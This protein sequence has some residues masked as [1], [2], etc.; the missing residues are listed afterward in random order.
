VARLIGMT[1]RKGGKPT[2]PD[3]VKGI[4]NNMTVV[5]PRIVTPAGKA[6]IAARLAEEKAFLDALRA[7]TKDLGTL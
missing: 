3:M 7:E 2:V 5:P 4:E 6:L 1:D